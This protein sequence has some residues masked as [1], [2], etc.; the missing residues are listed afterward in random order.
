MSVIL[1]FK[2]AHAFEL[3][4]VASIV[5]AFLVASWQNTLT[6]RAIRAQ[7]FVNLL[8]L[9]IEA[10]FQ[11]GIRAITALPPYT[12]FVDFEVGES[13]ETKQT[14]YDAVV[15]LNL[16][17]VLGEEGYLHIQDAWDVYFWSYRKC[18][19]K[20]LPW[21][22][23]GHRATQP[24]VFPS[25]ERSCVVTSLVTPAQIAA[26]DNH[27][28][29]RHLKKYQRTSRVPRA[30]LLEVLSRPPRMPLG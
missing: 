14:I 5:A 12:R 11:Q 3:V 26:F 8:E 7:S 10:G 1:G 6:S 27:V 9:E 2:E 13:A 20:L 22:L 30:K 18:H 25:F 16:M 19:E 29:M 24:S 28:G 17:A 23:E 21:W 4:S 15:F